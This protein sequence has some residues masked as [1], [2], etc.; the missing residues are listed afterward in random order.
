MAFFLFFS[1]RSLAMYPISMGA[2]TTNDETP[3]RSSP[4]KVTE[5]PEDRPVDSP[6]DSDHS[7]PHAIQPESTPI[8]DRNTIPDSNP[9]PI[10]DSN[11]N[12]IPDPNRLSEREER[13]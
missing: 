11:P 3:P 10:P 2:E 6:G 7:E 9:E 1:E 8:P 5:T 4:A 12:P 13:T